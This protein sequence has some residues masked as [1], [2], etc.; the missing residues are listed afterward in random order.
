MSKLYNIFTKTLFQ[1]TGKDQ[2]KRSVYINYE[3]GCEQKAC[4]LPVSL[5]GNGKVIKVI[6]RLAAALKI[7]ET[8]SAGNVC[9]SIAKN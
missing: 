3:A 1:L 5:S 4:H 8:Q 9:S 7:R 2:S 6:H